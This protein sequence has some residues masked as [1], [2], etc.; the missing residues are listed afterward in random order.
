[1]EVVLGREHQSRRLSVMRDGNMQLV[2]NPGSVPMDVSHNHA[3]F[4]SLGK[5]K[6][7][8]KNLNPRNVTYVN[9]IAIESKTIS[10]ADRIELGHSRY[11]IAWAVVTGPKQEN[12]DIRHL[13]GI[14][15]DYKEKLKTIE[16]RQK[17]TG[18]LSSIPMAFTMSAGA[19]TWLTKD[20]MPELANA[21]GALS[22]IGLIIF[23]YTLFRRKNDSSRD[24]KEELTKTMYKQYVCPK[25]GKFLGMQDYD[26]LAQQMDQCPHCKA[27]FIK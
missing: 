19:L 17:N 27:K 14:W 18:L 4:R 1:M 5:G 11:P 16:D 15:E 3:S 6:W 22:V 23:F 7:E 10:E 2:G 12:V 13:Q 21:L 8:I 24:E 9:G 25:C 26:L 20:T